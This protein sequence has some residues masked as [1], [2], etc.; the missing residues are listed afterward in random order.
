MAFFYLNK[1][2]SSIS[3]EYLQKEFNKFG[4]LKFIGNMKDDSRNEGFFS[5][6]AEFK[7]LL[8]EKDLL[9][10]CK[11]KKILAIKRKEDGNKQNFSTPKFTGKKE[12]EKKEINNFSTIFNPS[13]HYYKDNSYGKDI[14][15][16]KITNNFSELYDFNL[17]KEQTFELTTIYPGLLIGSGYNHP[18]LKDNNDDFQLGFYFDH[19]TGLPIISGSSI[20]GMIRSVCEKE[21][22]MKDVYEKT[23]PLSI[24]E[25]NKTVFYD[26]YIISTHDENKGRIFGSDYITS[27]YSNEEHGIFKE[28]NPIKF[29]KILSGVTF[30][31]QFKCDKK[32]LDLF[33][34]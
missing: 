17:P 13:F 2:D 1:I 34:I 21:N 22:F 5:T 29:L 4:D 31:F 10:F 19:T 26:A 23:V 28:P 12:N 9:D 11:N 25:D 8:D 32:Y 6:I 7:N 18:K 27:H 33:K 30:K 16:F 20:K 24:F 15:N 3:K 14:E